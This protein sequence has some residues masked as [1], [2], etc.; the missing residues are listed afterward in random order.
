MLFFEV[1]ASRGKVFLISMFVV[2]FFASAIYFFVA[3]AY[4]YSMFCVEAS[5]TLHLKYI[6]FILCYQIPRRQPFYCFCSFC[7]CPACCF[8][9]FEFFTNRF[10]YIFPKYLCKNFIMAIVCSSVRNYSISWVNVLFRSYLRHF[11]SVLY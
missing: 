11:H 9:C 5:I 10:Y 1:N 3:C 8:K 2:L 7:L 6:Y 4:G